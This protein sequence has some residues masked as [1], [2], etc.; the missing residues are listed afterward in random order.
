MF[1][2]NVIAATHL[3]YRILLNER[4]SFHV[5]ID[6]KIHLMLAPY[7]STMNDSGVGL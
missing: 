3:S 7:M 1:R 5:C 4:S 2:L 6:G